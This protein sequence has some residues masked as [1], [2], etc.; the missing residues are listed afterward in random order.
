LDDLVQVIPQHVQLWDRT[1]GDAGHRVRFQHPEMGTNGRTRPSP[2]PRPLILRELLGV[3][4]WDWRRRRFLRLAATGARLFRSRHVRSRFGAALVHRI[5]ANGHWCLRELEDQLEDEAEDLD[6]Q[7]DVLGPL[8][9]FTVLQDDVGRQ[10]PNP[11]LPHQV[12]P[13]VVVDLDDFD[14]LSP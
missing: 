11:V 5:V 6:E 1:A 7:E 12:G 9:F 8:H 2:K 14:A 4:D 3:H 10:A 13:S